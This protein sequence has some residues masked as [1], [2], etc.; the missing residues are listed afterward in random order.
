MTQVRDIMQKNV[1]TIEYNKTAHDAATVLKEKE[2]SFLVIIKDGKPSGVVSERDIV[3]KIA[4]ED[5]IASSIQLEDIMSKK[6]RWVKQD[7]PI[8]FAVQK[9]LN[10]N[11]RRLIVL[12]NEDLV[13]VVTQTDLAEF[14]RSKLLINGTIENIETE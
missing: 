4:A 10:N 3:K 9:M 13:G 7:T 14:L 6:F 8:E 2:I 1:I 11:I 12:E 5:L